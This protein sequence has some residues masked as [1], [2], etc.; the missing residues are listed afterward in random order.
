MHVYLLKDVEKV[1][2]AG[3][4]IKVADGHAT[5]F[6]IPRKLAIKVE[7]NAMPFY[8]SRVKKVE[9]ERQVLNSKVAML[10][11]RLK[12]MHL[13]LQKKVHDDDKLYGSVGADEIVA[14]LKEKGIN[15]SK[16]QVEFGK[17]VRSLGEHKITIR[18]SSKLRPEVTLKI[19]A[20]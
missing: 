10:A 5:N 3:Q 15:I 11:E 14:L 1:G 19:T 6:L 20:E 18:L 4:V 13:T 7:K 16:K 17:A 12:N 2:M 9:V 8:S